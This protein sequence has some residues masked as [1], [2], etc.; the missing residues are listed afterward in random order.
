MTED[1]EICELIKKAMRNQQIAH[2][3]AT[4]ISMEQQ[5]QH[6]QHQQQ[7]QRKH[8]QQH[9]SHQQHQQ[10][11]NVTHTTQEA[12]TIP[13]HAL[14]AFL[15]THHVISHDYPGSSKELYDWILLSTPSPSLS[16]AQHDTVAESSEKIISSVSGTPSEDSSA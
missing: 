3:T 7:H 8:P 1:P 14:R 11:Q 2:Q 12:I 15:T 9:E 6:Q 4:A 10:H 13:F 16:S 5:H